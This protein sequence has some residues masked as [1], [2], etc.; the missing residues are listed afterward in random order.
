MA[1]SLSFGDGGTGPAL[2]DDLGGTRGPEPVDERAP[3]G[4]EAR[5]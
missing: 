3:A 5:R 2:Q 4:E 1:R